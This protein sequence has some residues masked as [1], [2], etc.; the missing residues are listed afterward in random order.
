MD[1]HVD[2]SINNIFEIQSIIQNILD[3]K[4]SVDYLPPINLNM[5]MNMTDNSDSLERC[6]RNVET[7]LS[8]THDHV[9]KRNLVGDKTYNETLDSALKL[10]NQ[11]LRKKIEPEIEKEN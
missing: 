1:D 5:D 2:L 9:A 3:K 7:L 6:R 10:F 8:I 11:E 4:I